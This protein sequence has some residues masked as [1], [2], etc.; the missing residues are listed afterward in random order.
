MPAR[1]TNRVNQLS[2]SVVKAQSFNCSLIR[3]KTSKNQSNTIQQLMESKGI[4]AT[5]VCAREDDNPKNLRS[6]LASNHWDIIHFCGH[7][8]VDD[9][10]YIGHSGG[11][12]ATEFVAS[13]CRAGPPR[14]VILNACKSGDTS[15]ET[16]IAGISGPIAEQF[17]IRGVDAVVAT[18]WEIWD[19]A[20]RDFSIGFSDACD[21]GNPSNLNRESIVH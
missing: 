5:V 1:K 18:R 16:D 11:L 20:A 6:I 13:C 8:S 14:L 4:D 21:S 17:C 3:T 2:D 7:M 15:I 19:V 12:T 10:Q 9:G